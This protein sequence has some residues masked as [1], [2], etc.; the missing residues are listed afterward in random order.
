[1]TAHTFTDVSGTPAIGE[2][3]YWEPVI[4]R[5]AEIDAEVARLASIPA[6]T[7]GRRSSVFTHPRSPAGSPSL[8]PG[9]RVSLDVLLPGET[10]A[11][12]RHTSTQ[13]GFCI[14]GAGARRHRGTTHAFGRYDVWNHPSWRPYS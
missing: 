11:P 14:A 7:N 2:P 3:D 12:I 4:F 10:T 9:I 13:V 8:A 6:P 1:M 5:A